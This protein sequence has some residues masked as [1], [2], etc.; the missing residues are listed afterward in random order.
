MFQ[1]V[2]P[3]WCNKGCGMCYPVCEM[4]HIKNTLLIIK[5]SG[6]R[7]AGWIDECMSEWKD[8]WMG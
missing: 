1:L 7:L 8:V 5:K 4:V 6:L 3:N 2:L